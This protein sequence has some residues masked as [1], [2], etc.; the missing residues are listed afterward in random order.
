V[1]FGDQ[2][3]GLFQR[4]V[5]SDGDDRMFHNGLHLVGC[6]FGAGGD[7]G[8]G[9]DMV[10]KRFHQIAV[11]HTIPTIESLSVT[12]RRRMRRRDILWMASI[13]DVSGEITST[14]L[15]MYMPTIMR[16]HYSRCMSHTFQ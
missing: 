13:R 5:F 14:S 12:T 8:E 11:T 1:P 4:L 15:V 9:V 6:G 2:F 10:R 16:A 3:G 7:R